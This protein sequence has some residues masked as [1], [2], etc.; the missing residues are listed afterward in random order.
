[1]KLFDDL[2]VFTLCLL[3]SRLETKSYVPFSLPFKYST[4][5]D[6]SLF[7]FFCVWQV[8]ELDSWT[9]NTYWGWCFT[10]AQFHAFDVCMEGCHLIVQEFC[11]AIFHVESFRMFKLNLATAFYY[12]IGVCF[13]YTLELGR[14]RKIQRISWI[15]AVREHAWNLYFG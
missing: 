6:F 12:F 5:I 7:C 10:C 2:D 14:Q 15:H 8:L 11:V 1:M 3:G 9:Y 13:I 4:F